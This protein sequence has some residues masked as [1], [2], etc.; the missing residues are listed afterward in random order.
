[1]K[2]NH[3]SVVIIAV[4][5]LLSGLLLLPGCERT[6]QGISQMPNLDEITFDTSDSGLMYSILESGEGESPD[7]ENLIVAHYSGWLTDGRL[8]DK[9][10]G[11]EPIR[12]RL[13]MGR[14]IP[15]WEEA[16]AMMTPGEHRLL[17]I[18]P[19]LAYGDQSRENIPANSTLVFYVH[20][21]SVSD[22]PNTNDLDMFI[23]PSGLNI[24][25]YSPVPGQNTPQQGDTLH[26]VV[27]GWLFNGDLIY[28]SWEQEPN[29]IYTSIYGV[30]RQIEGWVEGVATMT[31]H[32]GRLLVIPPE[33]G[34]G[35][36]TTGPIPANS[37]LVYDIQLIQIGGEAPEIERATITNST[38]ASD[39]GSILE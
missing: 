35:G 9:S 24:F 32:S 39:L 23:T 16:I 30:T 11:L 33:L 21:I 13:G 7:P 1:M 14:V 38:P 31:P 29:H 4:S 3:F 6:E 22:M 2:T 5:L 17:V 10:Y 37:T 26:M 18:P 28:D 27:K 12:F 8:F 36:R 15:G 20:L 25:E 34:Y 19:E